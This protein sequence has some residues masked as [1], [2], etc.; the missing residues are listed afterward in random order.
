MTKRSSEGLLSPIDISLAAPAHWPLGQLDTVE[1]EDSVDSGYAEW[2]GPTPLVLSPPKTPRSQRMSTLSLL[3]SP[4]GTPA[5]ILSPKFGPSQASAWPTSPSKP[6]N[7][8]AQNESFSMDSSEDLDSPSVHAAKQLQSRRSTHNEHDPQ[9]TIRAPD[10]P[11][12]PSEQPSTTV[13]GGLHE[14]G[15]MP[16]DGAFIPHSSAMDPLLVDSVCQGERSTP[17]IRSVIPPAMSPEEPTAID[18]IPS[19][20]EHSILAYMSSPDAEMSL[21]FSAPAPALSPVLAPVL[22]PVS[23]PVLAPVLAPVPDA[24]PSPESESIAYADY[25]DGH[26]SS[27][28]RGSR[29]Q[30]YPIQDLQRRCSG[31]VWNVTPCFSYHFASISPPIPLANLSF[32]Y[33]FFAAITLRHQAVPHIRLPERVALFS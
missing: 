21:V 32:I 10:I 16:D 23:A 15:V 18:A 2:V 6:P 28:E 13:A 11:L 25:G 14:E 26:L 19:R 22:V 33:I 1:R 7:T 29:Y 8:E 27:T 9:S 3:S 31:F 17:D 4:F 5:R 30:K 20:E 24:T 12:V